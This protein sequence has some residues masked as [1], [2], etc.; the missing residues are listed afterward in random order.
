MVDHSRLHLAK[1]SSEVQVIYWRH[2][3]LATCK[4]V[5]LAIIFSEMHV[6]YLRY[7]VYL[8]ESIYG[9][10]QASRARA[11]E[12]GPGRRDPG[13]WTIEPGPWS[14]GSRALGTVARALKGKW[15]LG[16]GRDAKVLRGGS[17]CNIDMQKHDV[18]L[19]IEN[20]KCREVGLWR[21]MFNTSVREAS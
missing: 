9:E 21:L 2:L 10:S 5:N 4:T 19:N 13:V 8:A 17:G 6:V 7:Y 14:L 3:Y 18:F 20:S 11:L 12:P 1:L 15:S 16:P